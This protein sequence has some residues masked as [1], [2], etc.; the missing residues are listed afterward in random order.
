MT[1]DGIAVA[2]WDRVHELV[3]D[4]VNAS[5]SE[6]KAAEV[7]A[8]ASLF[9]LLDQLDDKYGPKPSLLATRAD[10]V[11][12]SEHREAL[13]RLAYAEAARGN[14]Q[15][16]IILVAQSLTEFYLEED[17]DFDQGATWLGTWRQ[18]LGVSPA[19]D[20][21]AELARLEELLLRGGAA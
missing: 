19:K 20:D 13:L 16:N 9:M 7:R 18:L 8:R 3:V 14:D 12:T 21:R 6:D 2:V 15:K 17:G 5:V 4:V 1:S 11:E 10:Y